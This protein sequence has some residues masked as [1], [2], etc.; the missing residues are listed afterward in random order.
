M[1]RLAM[2]FAL[3]ALSLLTASSA[4]SQWLKIPL[5]GTPRTPDGKPNLTAPA[6]KTPDGK[7]DLS[8][9]WRRDTPGANYLVNLGAGGAEISM[10]PWAEAL[11]KS[12]QDNLAKDRPSGRC[13]PHALPDAMMVSIF[14]ITPTPGAMLILYEEFTHFRQIFTDGRDFPN[15]ANPTERIGTWFGY[16]IG[17]WE[18]DT[19]VAETVGFNDKSW[20]DDTGHPHTDA[21]RVT[22]RFRRRDFGHMDIEITIDD[23]KTYTK[24]FT[25]K[26][27]FALLPDTEFI[28]DICDNE[29]DQPHMIGK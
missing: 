22:E 25:V 19:F 23:P 21:M 11:Y 13:L 3:F 8:G 7:T 18:G 10:L 17:K 2:G 5:P 26:V 12:R 1:N 28:E 15:R 9:I 29:R 14:K 24:P 16:S 4:S 6:S 20:L 27:A